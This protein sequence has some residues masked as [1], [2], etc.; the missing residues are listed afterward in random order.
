[1]DLLHGARPASLSAVQLADAVS[2]AVRMELSGGDRAAARLRAC[3]RRP[4][5][6]RAIVRWRGYGRN[7][8]EFS[9]RLHDLCPW[10]RCRPR[11]RTTR[12]LTDCGQGGGGRRAIWPAGASVL[13]GAGNRRCYRRRRRDGANAVLAVH[14][15]DR[16]G[17]GRSLPARGL[18]GAR[19]VIDRIA[20]CR[21]LGRT[22]HC[23][24]PLQCSVPADVS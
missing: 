16:P 4:D 12:L 19:V 13:L 8:G 10:P 23:S 15:L 1:M 5:S 6:A 3:G 14:R 22:D 20:S 2:G 21:C 17:Q 11:T 24:R 7:V 18:D 9:R